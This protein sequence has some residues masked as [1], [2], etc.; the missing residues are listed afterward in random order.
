MAFPVRQEAIRTRL[1]GAELPDSTT[2]QAFAA[3]SGLLKQQADAWGKALK[4]A[5]AGTAVAW[6]CP[7][8]SGQPDGP[9]GV[10]RRD[11]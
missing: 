9:V 2:R 4:D 3:C 8:R 10:V 6:A 11:G 5:G 7:R 1:G